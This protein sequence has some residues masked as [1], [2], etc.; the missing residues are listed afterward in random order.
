WHVTPQKTTAARPEAPGDVQATGPQER[1]VPI[2]TVDIPILYEDEGQ[3]HMGDSLPHSLCIG[4]IETGLAAHLA[5]RPDC[6]VLVNMNAYTP[7][8]ARWAYVSPDVMVA[9]PTQPLPDD[10][11]SYRIGVNGPAPVLAVEV[12]SRRSFQQQDLTNKP[13]IYAELGVSE[14]VLVDVTGVFLPQRLWIKRLQGDQTWIDGQDADGG[15]TSRLGF[16]LLI[17]ADNK[18]RVVEAAAGRPYA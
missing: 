13:I 12:L 7:R 5:S 4:I 2:I 8:T 9:L 16:R 17:D 18:L 14:Y 1:E 6:R 15:V 3:E 11:A 10:L